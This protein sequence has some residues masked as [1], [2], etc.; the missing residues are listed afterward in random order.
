MAGVPPR[1]RVLPLFRGKPRPR[2]RDAGGPHTGK[3]HGPAARCLAG[4]TVSIRAPLAAIVLLG[5]LALPALSPPASAA[6]FGAHVGLAE[7][8]M[9]DRYFEAGALLADLDVFLPP[10]EPQTDNAAFAHGL[11]DRAWTGS[12]HAWS[13]VR[14]WH[15]HL[16][17]DV[18]FAVAVAAVLA[19]YPSYTTTD[20]RLGFDYWT[21][22][23]H[24]FSMDFDFLL[25]DA[26]V[27]G[28]IAGGLSSTDVAG[29]RDAIYRS[30]YSTDV[31]APG[32]FLQVNASKL[33]GALNPQLMRDLE[34]FY[35]AFYAATTAGYRDPFPRLDAMMASL[36]GLVGRMPAGLRSSIEPL[37]SQVQRIVRVR[38]DG[39]IPSGQAVLLEIQDLAAAAAGPTAGGRLA[40]I[41]ADLAGQIAE[42]LE[43]PP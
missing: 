28:L 38:P 17:Q 12:R 7:A 4:E 21:V 23:K 2:V 39:W 27:Q 25:A 33:F 40:A 34:P 29:V 10:A 41:T 19:A 26:E 35:D 42:A 30:L 14:G 15:E 16:D 37:E 20:I 32:L 24:P 22:T 11:L 3:L 36:H 5:L 13:L 31:S 6:N 18:R 8:T 43:P 9:R 1:S